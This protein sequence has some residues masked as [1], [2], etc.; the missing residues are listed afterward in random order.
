MFNGSVIEFDENDRIDETEPL[1]QEDE[2]VFEQPNRFD[3][4]VD[5]ESKPF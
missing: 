3:N 2:E 5:E 1:L 4:R